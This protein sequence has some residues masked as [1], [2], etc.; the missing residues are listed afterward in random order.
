MS[1]LLVMQLGD[2]SWW[3]A[4]G[5]GETWAGRGFLGVWVGMV[6]VVMATLVWRTGKEDEVLKREFGKLWETW[7]RGT[8]YRLVPYVY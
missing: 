1:G 4:S 2:G 8:R 6:G 3:Q 7:A 5:L